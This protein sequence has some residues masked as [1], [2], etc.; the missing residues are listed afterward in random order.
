MAFPK[1]F[2][3]YVPRTYCIQTHVYGVILI[4]KNRET[5]VIKGRQSGKWSFPKG[6]GLKNESPLDASLRELK[7]ETG[8]DLGTNPRPDDEIRFP[9]GTY[10]IF[11]LDETITLNPQDQKEV[12]DAKWIQIDN[13]KYLYG[14]MDLKLFTRK[15]PAMVEC[16]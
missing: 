8:I 15:L 12:E 14:N 5:V 1:A 16:Q 7:E 2:R 11:Y 10:F 4:T 6:H 3:S 9:T 13:L